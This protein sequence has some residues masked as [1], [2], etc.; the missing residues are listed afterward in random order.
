MNISFWEEGSMCVCEKVWAYNNVGVST[1][2]L[3]TALQQGLAFVGSQLSSSCSKGPAE[4]LWWMNSSKPHCA[5]VRSCSRCLSALHPALLCPPLIVFGSLLA[6]WWAPQ[7]TEAGASSLAKEKWV[8]LVSWTGAVEAEGIIPAGV[9]K[10][11]VAPP[12]WKEEEEKSHFCWVDQ[13]SCLLTSL[14][15]TEFYAFSAEGQA[16][17]CPAVSIAGRSL[18][19]A[20]EASFK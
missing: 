17:V 4:E 3:K 19:E 14:T 7:L 9:K 10:G 2:G 5:G 13:L 1:T 12:L 18:A 16:R 11:E 6:T 15:K 20:N 8:N